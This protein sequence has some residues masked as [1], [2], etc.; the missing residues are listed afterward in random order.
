M[1]V[2]V[3]HVHLWGLILFEMR[4]FCIHVLREWSEFS[5]PSEESKPSEESSW[6]SDLL[7]KDQVFLLF[8]P[9]NQ[10]YICICCCYKV[11]LNKTLLLMKFMSDRDSERCFKVLKSNFFKGYIKKE[12]CPTSTG[13]ELR[14]FAHFTP[15]INQ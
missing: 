14:C 15:R 8:F 9:S 6:H 4:W 7:Q 1:V 13:V 12:D 5:G 10:S 2:S 3:L 11:F